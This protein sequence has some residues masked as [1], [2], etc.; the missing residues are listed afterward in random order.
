MYAKASESQLRESGARYAVSVLSVP[1]LKS[2]RVAI[3]A[4]TLE[5][6]AAM[7][8]IVHR[9]TGESYEEFLAGLAKAS[10]IEAPTREDLA[11]LDRKRK[12]RTLNKDWKSP[13]D[14]DA[15]I[16]RTLPLPDTCLKGSRLRALRSIH[17]IREGLS[18]T[19]CRS[20]DPFPQL[21]HYP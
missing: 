7:R 10:G 17:V 4:T 21:L 3:D 5:A 15:R 9:D 1:L 11:Q 2:K 20:G 19:S 16:T 8:S 6:N 13:V 14:G 18:S 12:K